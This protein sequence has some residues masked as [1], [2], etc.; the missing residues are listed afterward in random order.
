MKYLTTEEVAEELRTTPPTVRYWR[1]KDTGPKSF[2]VG[3][4]VLYD[5]ADVDAWIAQARAKE[6]SG[7]AA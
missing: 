1:H 4:R 5:R 3:K 6:T 7:S 2:R